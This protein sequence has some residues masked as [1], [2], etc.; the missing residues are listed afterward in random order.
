GGVVLG[1]GAGGGVSALPLGRASAGA[2]ID[3]RPGPF[4]LRASAN[5]R[6]RFAGDV[7]GGSSSEAA[8][9]ARVEL[10][11]PFARAFGR[12]SPGEGSLVHWI[13]PSLSLR[14]ALAAQ[15]GSFFAPIGGAVPPASWVGALGFSTALGRYAG[16]A[17]R[18]DVRAGATGGADTA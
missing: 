3:A 8:A 13:T 7:P 14:G 2:E 6:G 18:L 9:A 15:R 5:A 1:A 11:L 10:S 17:L 12:A 16:P 4:E